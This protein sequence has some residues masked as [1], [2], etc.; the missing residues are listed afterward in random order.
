MPG[1]NIKYVVPHAISGKED[2]TLHMR[3][4]R[5]GLKATVKV[6]GVL[7]KRFRSVRPSEMIVLD[8]KGD[9]LKE[10]G[11]KGELVVDCEMREGG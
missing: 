7:S 11:L 1:D 3:V 5:P 6:G 4:T 8:L 10:A 9:A 2:V